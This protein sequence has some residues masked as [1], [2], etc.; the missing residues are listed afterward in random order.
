LKPV[1]EM[2]RAFSNSPLFH[3]FGHFIG[4][5]S[6]KVFTGF[7]RRIERFNGFFGKMLT[8][9]AHIEYIFAK[10]FCRISHFFLLTIRLLL[11]P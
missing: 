7:D 10:Q 2:S 11:D 1:R 9:N 8:H 3:G 6:I 4:N 5:A